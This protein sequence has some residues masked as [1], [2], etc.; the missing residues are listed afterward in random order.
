MYMAGGKRSWRGKRKGG[1]KG[2]RKGSKT[3]GGK[4]AFTRNTLVPDRLVTRLS[5]NDNIPLVKNTLGYQVWN[6]R[7][8]SIYD[9]DYAIIAGHQP[10]GYDQWN[11]FYQNYRVYK[12]KVI[13]EFTNLGLTPVQVGFLPYSSTQGVVSGVDDDT[14]EQPHV[15][16]KSISNVDGQNRCTLSKM[17]D[18]PRILGVSHLQFKASTL[19]QTNFG[20]NPVTP[21]LCNGAAFA[22]TIDLNQ[23]TINVQMAIRIIFYVELMNRKVMAISVPE[24]KDKDGHWTGLDA[25]RNPI[26]VAA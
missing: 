6:C 8:N 4:V 25:A 15:V 1:R 17:V 13:C 14:F 22:R 23:T 7:L 21:Y 16:K 11:S 12:A 24:G 3:D 2:M 9:P 5:Y 20:N 18:I 10:L 26:P 19:S